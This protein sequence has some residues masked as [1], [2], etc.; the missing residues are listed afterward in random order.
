MSVW[1]LFLAFVGILAY[2]GAAATAQTTGDIEGTVTGP[3]GELLAN[4]TVE[5]TGSKLQGTRATISD[6]TGRYRLPSVP[7][8][9]YR[10][11]A[12]LEG[13]E[14]VEQALTLSLDATATLD[15]KLTL[16]VKS[17]ATV[18]AEVPLVDVTSTTTGTDYTSE[19]VAKLPVQRNYA[20]IV[21]ANPGVSTDIGDTEGRFLALSIYGATSAENQWIVDGVNTTNV[22]KGIQGKAIN[23]EFVQEVEIKTGGYPAEYGR[24]LG[25]VINV[26]TKSGGNAFHGETFVYYDSTDTTAERQ[27]KQGDSEIASMR[28]PDARRFDYGVDLG[29]FILKDRLWF[30]GAYNRVTLDG[31]VSRVASSTYVSKDDRFPF[32]AVES[33]YSGKLT[34]NATSSTTLVGTVFADPSSTS[35]AAGADPRQGL[36]VQVT[37]IVS[38]DPSSWSSTRAQGGTDYGL[39]LT[40]LFGSRALATLQGSHHQDRNSLGA[41]NRIQY[42]DWT[43][44]GGTHDRPCDF[45][46]EPNSISGG[47]GRIRL[48]ASSRDQ[49]GASISLYGGSHELKAGGDYM[50]GQTKLNNRYTG[51]QLVQIFSEY[52]E[53]YYAHRYIAVSLEDPTPV[54]GARREAQV[55]DYGLYLQDSWKAAQGLTVNAGLRWDGETTRNYARETVLR[56]DDQWQ[57]RIG[58]VWDPWRD[59]TTKLFAFA[60]RFSY[61]LP[62]TAAAIAFG[63]LT[64]VRV[65]N[66]DPVS[67]VQDPNVFRHGRRQAEGGAFGDAV[68]V[69][70]K[71]TYQDEVTVGVERMLAPSLSVGLKGTYRRLGRA[72]ADRCD[73]DY[74]RPET[75]YRGC[76]FINPG[77]GGAFA[78]GN[79]PTCDWLYDA[80]E[81][82]QCFSTGPAS[83][84]ARRLYRGI[85]LLARKTVKD[86]MWLQASYVYSS[87]RGNYDGAVNEGIYAQTLGQTTPGITY[88]F[89]FPLLWYNG[90][91]ALTLDRPNR[92]RVDGYWVTPLRLSIGLQA[93]AES[94]APLNRLGY[95]PIVGP[96]IFLVPRG[97]AGRLPT[98]WEANLTLSY[99]IAIGPVT[100]TLQ[101]YLFN[102]FNNQ[103]VTSREQSWTTSQPE[104]YPA[105][106]TDPNQEQN[107]PNYG[108]VT[109]R[110]APRSFRAALRVAF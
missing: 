66:F 101:A 54:D 13:F 91:G 63:N 55:L 64:S 71:A 40:R 5:A 86:Q 11:R 30:F 69:G 27:F 78:S 21:R 15:L 28:A 29:G 81:G 36:N 103:I 10:V 19:I 110:S 92:F 2:S 12:T 9:K 105:T 41:V 72:L 1:R 48:N 107:N 34:W 56:F 75:G 16:T 4:I 47:F 33:L 108:K 87:L 35:G 25:G 83:P 49:F 100:A 24:A 42:T 76:A 82:I 52:G 90:Y 65:F 46:P 104:G 59:G 26:I 58:V 3:S 51:G 60:G 17:A 68:D 61:A 109:G 44:A 39:R 85:E 79:L 37:P 97:S 23:N 102:V 32:D 98:L 53:T 73:F 6:H 62:T 43:C 88:D 89:S 96:S 67:L 22:Y 18:T 93:F 20:D 70:V 50:D 77:S 95:H 45:P 94:G 99:P 84:S 57:P 31:H 106:I 74:T 38:P 8:G 7:P 14:T 80:P